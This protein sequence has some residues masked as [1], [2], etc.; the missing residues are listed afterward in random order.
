MASVAM[1]LAEGRVSK[2]RKLALA[3]VIHCSR[4]NGAKCG[5]AILL[6][7]TRELFRRDVGLSPS[8]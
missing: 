6:N 5:F 8:I 1:P 7:K 4:R 2:H 3:H